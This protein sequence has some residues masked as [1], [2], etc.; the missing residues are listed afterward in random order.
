MAGKIWEE[1]AGDSAGA[2]QDRGRIKNLGWAFGMPKE[3]KE[4]AAADYKAEKCPPE[5]TGGKGEASI[6]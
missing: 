6:G 3:D 4:P 5:K 2:G 1:A